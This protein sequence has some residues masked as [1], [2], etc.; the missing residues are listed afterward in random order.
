[1]KDRRGEEEGKI[2]MKGEMGNYGRGG[3]E[4]EG[5]EGKRRDGEIKKEGKREREMAIREG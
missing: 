2:E 3:G 5:K 1:M 4:N